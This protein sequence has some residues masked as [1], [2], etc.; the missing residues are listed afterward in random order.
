MGCYGGGQ[1]LQVLEKVLTR[2]DDDAV[3]DDSGFIGQVSK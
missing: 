2:N 3:D 1:R